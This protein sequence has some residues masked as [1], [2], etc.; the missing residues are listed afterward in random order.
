MMSN[1]EW[2]TITDPSNP[3]KVYQFDL[4]FFLSRHNCIYGRGCQGVDLNP[5][6]GCCTVGACMSAEELPRVLRTVELAG[7]HAQHAKKIG[8]WWYNKREDGE[9]E[10]NT[11]VVQG[12]CIFSNQDTGDPDDPRPG[13]ALV[14]TAI[15][16]G[17]DIDDARPQACSLYPLS[18]THN[19]LDDERTLIVVGPVRRAQSWAQEGSDWWCTDDH[20]A[21]GEKNA[22]A[23][24][25]YE[26]VL[27]RYVGSLVYDEFKAYCAARFGTITVAGY[28]SPTDPKANGRYSTV[29][30]TLTTKRRK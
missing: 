10:F 8:K 5:T 22:A 27:R 14:H 9:D 26:S 7:D 3:A 2:V 13:C 19:T 15:F 25:Y 20:A 11:R 16:H 17:L 12:A 18:L 24:L 21:Y 28:G 4:T 23:F 30:V 1:V 29:P 6:N